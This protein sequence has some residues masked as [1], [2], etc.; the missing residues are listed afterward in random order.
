MDKVGCAADLIKDGETGFI[1]KSGNVNDLK[2]KINQAINSDLNSMGLNAFNFIQ[3]WSYEQIAKS[4]EYCIH[5][6]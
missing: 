4:I 5:N 2:D 6:S 3:P 1:F